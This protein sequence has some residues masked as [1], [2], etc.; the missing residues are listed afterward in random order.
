MVISRLYFV[1]WKYHV[2][3]WT[4]CLSTPFTFKSPH[5]HLTMDMEVNL[6]LDYIKTRTYQTIIMYKSNANSLLKLT[7]GKV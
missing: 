7:F 1:W 5:T 6:S 2:I 3:F 4:P